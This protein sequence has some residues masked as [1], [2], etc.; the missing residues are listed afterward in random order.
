M[1]TY[2]ELSF[3]YDKLLRQDIDYEDWSKFI[4]KKCN[5]YNIKMDKYIDLACGTCNITEHIH[6]SFNYTIALD[7]SQDML[8]I[9]EEK[10]RYENIKFIC[11]DI[12]ELNLNQRFDLAT[13]CLD[14]TNY[15]LSDNELI[16]YFNGVYKHL[17]S[18]GLFIFDMNSYY[19]LVNIMGNNLFNYDDQDIVYMWQ[20]TCE[21]EILDMELTFFVKEK[22]LYRRFDE[23]HEERAYTEEAIVKYLKA[24]G[25][26]ILEILDG[27]SDKNSTINS[28]RILYVVQKI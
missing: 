21:D 23:S 25:F 13:C 2:N 16:K 3:I 26:N 14:G 9:A 1:G 12:A 8:S 5:K 28:E 15:L 20:N 18:N 6:R 22:E 10:L 7:I 19:K 24:A 27:Y 4:L 11:Q 17:N